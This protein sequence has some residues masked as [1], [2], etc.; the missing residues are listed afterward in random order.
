M[1]DDTREGERPPWPQRLY[2]SVWLW[3]AVAVLFWFLSY[4]VWGMVD[5]MVIPGG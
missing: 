4:V 1:S 3:A 2:E 5:L